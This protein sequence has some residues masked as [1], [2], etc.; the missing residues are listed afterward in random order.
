M[1]TP[2]PPLHI[3]LAEDD[4]R[5][6]LVTRR[7]IQKA[8]VHADLTVLRDGQEVVDYILRSQEID[9]SSKPDLLLVDISLPRLG[10]M[11]ILAQLKQSSATAHL[12]IIILTTSNRQEDIQTAYALGAN[13]YIVKPIHFTEYVGVIRELF[14]F[15]SII[16]RL[17]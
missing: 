6:I 5:D 12:P 17:P 13:T 14:A 11:D 15:W 4:E 8:G 7:A 16:A 1:N 10:G 2:A 9:E 3:L